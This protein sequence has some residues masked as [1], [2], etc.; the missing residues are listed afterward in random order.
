MNEEDHDEALFMTVYE[1]TFFGK[2]ISIKCDRILETKKIRE[3]L[4]RKTKNKNNSSV[5]CVKEKH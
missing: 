2:T 5:S 1:R 3:E 4:T